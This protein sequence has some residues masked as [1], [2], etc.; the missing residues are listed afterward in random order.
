MYGNLL[1]NTAKD[2]IRR[3]GS[4]VTVSRLG[5][6]LTR[7]V[8][9]RPQHLDLQRVAPLLAEAGANVNEAQPMAFVVAA[10]EDI[11]EGK[12]FFHFDGWKRLVISVPPPESLE[13]IRL[14]MHCITV[15]HERL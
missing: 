6:E 11:R 13:G 2:I 7:T 9:A 4:A 5:S 14:T 8:Y 10:G 1:A 12:D 3:F 15:R